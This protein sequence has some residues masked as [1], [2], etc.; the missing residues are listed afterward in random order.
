MAD[1]HKHGFQGLLE[2]HIEAV[3]C[4]ASFTRYAGRELNLALNEVHRLSELRGD[5]GKTISFDQIISDSATVPDEVKLRLAEICPFHEYHISLKEAIGMGILPEPAIYLFPIKL[6]TQQRAEVG[7][8]EMEHLKYRSLY[9]H[10]GAMWQLN[11]MNLARGKQKQFIAECKTP[12]VKELLREIKGKRLICF[13]GSIEQAQMLGGEQAI[14][15]KK[16]SKKNITI[17]EKFNNFEIAEIYVNKMG[18]EGMNL[19][20]IEAGVIVQL[21]SGNDQGLSFLQR[22][23]RSLR[24]EDPEIFIFYA[25]ETQDEVYLKRALQNIDKK[26]I[27]TYGTRLC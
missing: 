12:Y 14:H 22:T 20:G 15:S 16:S 11:K 3:I 1:L 2:T 8:L 18:K 26:Y 13:C 21:D 10:D 25:V 19:P 9:E 7:R 27:K 4:Y 5:I 17:L 24:A 23:G 6:T